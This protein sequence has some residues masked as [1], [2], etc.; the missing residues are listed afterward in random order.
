MAAG[1]QEAPCGHAKP[2]KLTIGETTQ[3]LSLAI[4]SSLSVVGVRIQE[5][6]V[7]IRSFEDELHPA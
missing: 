2:G 4:L 1:S 5:L 7:V 6:G 3:L